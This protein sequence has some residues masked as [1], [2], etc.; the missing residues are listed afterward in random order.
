M[1]SFK[2]NG[3]M[4]YAKMLGFVKFISTS[5]KRFSLTNCSFFNRSARFD[6]AS[7]YASALVSTEI[8]SQDLTVLTF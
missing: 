8:V 7:L 6:I 3:N 2:S 1:V 5:F 4:I